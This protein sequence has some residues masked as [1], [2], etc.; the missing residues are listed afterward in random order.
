[1]KQDSREFSVRYVA[2]DRCTVLLVRPV[3]RSDRP[4]GSGKMQDI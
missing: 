1:M 4:M 3:R 2:I